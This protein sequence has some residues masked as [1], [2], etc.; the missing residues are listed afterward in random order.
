MKKAISTLII[1]SFLILTAQLVLAGSATWNA[2]PAN[3]G[4][5]IATNWTPATVPKDPAD[6]ATFG[7]SRITTITGTYLTVGS[8]VFNPGASAYTFK[9]FDVYDS[10]MSG[11]GIINNSGVLQTMELP[12]VPQGVGDEE[13]GNNIF[14]LSGNATAGTLIQYNVRG[15]SCADGKTDDSAIVTF[16]DETTA[17]GATF[18]IYPGTVGFY[19]CHGQGGYVE[20]DDSSSAEN[21]SFIT[22]GGTVVDSKQAGITFKDNS[23]GANATIT[24]YGASLSRA[25]GGEV[26]FIGNSTAQNA[27]IINEG[28]FVSGARAALTLFTDTAAADNATLIANGGRGDGGLIEFSGNSTGGTAHVQVFGNGNLDISYHNSPGVTVGSLEG[29]GIVFLG[30]RNL[31]VGS[32][33][34]STV[35]SGLIRF[36]GLARGGSGSLTKIGTGSLT[37]TGANTYTAGTI[38]NGGTLLVNNTTGS[39]LGTGA[40]RVMT[41]ILGGTGN[42]SGSVTVGTG[43]GV[44]AVLG[45]GADPYT[46][47]TLTAGSQLTLKADATYRVTLNSSVSSA[48]AVVA[49]GVRIS[50]AQI[51]LTDRGTSTLPPGTVF[52]VI[53]NTS[54]F[55]ISGTFSNLADGATVTVNG[56][57]FQAN[58]EG[59]DGNDLTLT[60]VP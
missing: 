29:D 34:A 10:T 25:N 5:G 22:K 60:V 30:D 41:G 17:G 15:S 26:D 9:Q 24:N 7:S 23:T 20:F 39:G 32:S 53:S 16:K 45:P 40:V 21:A 43:N 51:V 35:F 33:N 6:T 55:P 28:G 38:I 12:A 42:I 3:G 27:T 57:T 59:G 19:G 44:G 31:T 52:T 4:W 37:L 47:G 13:W 48:D 56:N 14:T 18:V 54:A 2:V 8:I 11:P 46:P 1:S 50:G 36:G 49:T 58:Y